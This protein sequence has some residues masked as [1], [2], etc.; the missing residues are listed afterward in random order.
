MPGD[1]AGFVTRTGFVRRGLLA[2]CRGFW[3]LS[4]PDMLQI[5]A[6]CVPAR[7]RKSSG[8]T[9]PRWLVRHVGRGDTR[10]AWKIDDCEADR[11]RAHRSP[12]VVR[13]A[14]YSRLPTHPRAR[15][16]MCRA[17]S[18]GTQSPTPISRSPLPPFA[19]FAAHRGQRGSTRRVIA[20]TYQAPHVTHF[21]FRR[22]RARGP[23]SAAGEISRVVCDFIL[24]RIASI[25]PRFASGQMAHARPAVHGIRGG[26]PTSGRTSRSGGASGPASSGVG[27][28]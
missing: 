27:T 7:H 10:C 5:P 24:T 22:R 13:S 1:C 18:G 12:R 26:R 4:R 17:R 25:R 16:A 20:G 11:E 15:L 8:A 6:S 19:S 28:P 3:W 9:P 21:R 23:C 14:S 2:A